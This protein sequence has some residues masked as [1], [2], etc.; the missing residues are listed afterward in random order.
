MVDGVFLNLSNIR[1]SSSKS[2]YEIEFGNIADLIHKEIKF[3]LVD[4]KLIFPEIGH[5]ANTF[6]VDA[7]EEGKTLSSCEDVILQLSKLGLKRGD[8]IG[9]VGGG[10]IQDIGTLVS[11][12]YMRGIDWCYFPT[13]LAAMGDSCIGGK[14]SINAG[15]FKNLVGNFYPPSAIG[16][17]VTFVKT[18]PQIEIVAGLSEIIKICYAR[19]ESVF[20]QA[21]ELARSQNLQGD[22]IKL[23]KI[24]RL[25]LASKKYFVEEDEFDTG[26]R[27]LLNFG[28]TF[29]HAIESA[30]EFAIPHGVAVL[31]GMLA[32][33]EHPLA[34]RSERTAKLMGICHELLSTVR[35]KF[36]E[37]SSLID[38]K[39]FSEAITIDKKNTGTNLNLVLPSV[40][41]LSIIPDSFES[42][43]IDRAATSLKIALERAFNEVR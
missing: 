3:L 20:D 23:H 27:K 12:I 30:T 39:V 10:C 13:T 40:A 42:G 24:V 37:T 11:S 33:I 14:S 4:S 18:L 5:I 15:P 41:G 7:F 19:G 2:E 26:I 43:A 28:H 8:T 6:K 34:H 21:N 25:S 22:P 32:A 17:D 36:M 16:I 38:Y 29:G 35:Q 31:I 1:I 9:V